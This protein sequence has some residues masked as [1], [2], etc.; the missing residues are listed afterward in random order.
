MG[1]G[2]DEQEESEFLGLLDEREFGPRE[3]WMER[4]SAAE[5]MDDGFRLE[6]EGWRCESEDID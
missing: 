5:G 1:S 2:R 4:Q 6:G 3:H